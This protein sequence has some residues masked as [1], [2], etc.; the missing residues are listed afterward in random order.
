M[1]AK[2]MSFKKAAVSKPLFHIQS[3]SQMHCISFIIAWALEIRGTFSG[4]QIHII[5]VHTTGQS[6]FVILYKSH[7]DLLFLLFSVMFTIHIWAVH[8]LLRQN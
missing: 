7:G 2:P 3:V 4:C 6:H 1:D 8:E 5:R